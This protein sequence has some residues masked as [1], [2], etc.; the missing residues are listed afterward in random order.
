MDDVAED[1]SGICS[2]DGDSGKTDVDGGGG[3]GSESEDLVSS[4]Q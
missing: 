4:T 1:E 3:G 2:S